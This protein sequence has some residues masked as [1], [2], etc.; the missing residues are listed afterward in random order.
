MAG[1]TIVIA[2]DHGPSRTLLSEFLTRRGYH[3]G[4]AADG[5][6]ALHLIRERTPNLVLADVAMPRMSGLELTRRLRAHH[7]TSRIPI[8]IVSALKDAPDVLAGYAAGADDYVS[9]PIDLNILAVKLEQ[10][11]TRESAHAGQGRFGK[12]VLLLH[13]RG[14]SGATTIAVN[15]A[16]LLMPSSAAGVALLDLNLEFGDAARLLQLIPRLSL[17]DLA[18]HTSEQVD[19]PFFTKFISRHALGV[20]VVIA[21]DRPEHAELVTLPAIQTAI[22]R[23]RQ[24]V[25]QVLIDA[26][27]SFSEHNLAAIDMADLVLIVSAPTAPALAATQDLLD[28]LDRVNHPRAKEM[29]LVNHNTPLG[30]SPEQIQDIIGRA[31]DLVIP[32]SDR[33][34]EAANAGQALALTDPN[35]EALLTLRELAARIQEA[36]HTTLTETQASN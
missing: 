3:V 1:E 7:T 31:P 16:C 19:E 23:L 24:R 27:P 25:D 35:D 15:L 4:L 17:V 2:E 9:K 33:F 8:I 22:D 21:S 11:L 34:V 6:E 20:Q 30:L 36:E 28:V 18:T 10:L 13:S 29:L 32:Y 26:A 12:V 14:G 5:L